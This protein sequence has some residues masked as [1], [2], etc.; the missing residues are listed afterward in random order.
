MPEVRR[1]AQGH[2]AGTM[3]SGQPRSLDVPRGK[4]NNNNTAAPGV[5]PCSKL[6]YDN[7]DERVN[8]FSAGA[9]VCVEFACAPG[10]AQASPG[11]SG[12]RPS[13]PYA[14]GVN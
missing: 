3:K 5:A 2:A 12:V 14:G 7:T 10:S 4:K 1:R 13:H 6:F 11:V 9:A 8:K